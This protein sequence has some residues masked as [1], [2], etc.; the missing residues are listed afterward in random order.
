M[1][2]IA[3]HNLHFNDPISQRGTAPNREARSGLPPEAVG[4]LP[5][6]KASPI[7]QCGACG[8]NLS[9]CAINYHNQFY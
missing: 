8:V 7:L 2:A 9:A 5:E 4:P 1:C 6:G 3:L